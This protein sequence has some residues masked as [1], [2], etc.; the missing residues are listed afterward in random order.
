VQGKQIASRKANFGLAHLTKRRQQTTLLALPIILFQSEAEAEAGEVLL[1]PGV[2]VPQ[3]GEQLVADAIASVSDVSI[4]GVFD[5]IQPC[6]T[7]KSRICCREKESRG[8]MNRSLRG[9]MAARPE[10]ALPR[11]NRKST[12]SA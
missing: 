6:S 2:E 3:Q 8:R 7:R 5:E 9:R 1:D 12:V 4:A 10:R 11:N